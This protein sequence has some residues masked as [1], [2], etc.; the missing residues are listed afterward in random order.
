MVNKILTWL[1]VGF[2]LLSVGSGLYINHLEKQLNEQQTTTETVVT[3]TVHDTVTVEK[4]GV[5][6]YK[7]RK[8][9]VWITQPEVIDSLYA[10]LADS[11]KQGHIPTAYDST[12]FSDGT[13]LETWYEYLPSNKFTYKHLAPPDSV[14]TNTT[15][16]TRIIDKT[17][18]M[19]LILGV[20]MDQ[21][22]ITKTAEIGFKAGLRI[23]NL[24]GDVTMFKDHNMYGVNIHIPVKKPF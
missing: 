24:S 22:K 10:A 5:I 20:A 17:P 19:S 12:T 7:T 14:I 3:V 21:D 1:L 4:P 15:T 23:K 6:I 8:D 11:V 9:T 18:P 16:I 2:V 13:Y